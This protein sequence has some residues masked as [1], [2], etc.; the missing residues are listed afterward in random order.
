MACIECSPLIELLSWECDEGGSTFEFTFQVVDTPTV[1]VTINAG[2]VYELYDGIYYGKAPTGVNIIVYLWNHEDC[3]SARLNLREICEEGTGS[4]GGTGGTGGTGECEPTVCEYQG[5]SV[6]AGSV[7]S[8]IATLESQCTL[9]ITLP[10]CSDPDFSTKLT[11][12][13]VDLK[14]AI[15]A[16]YP[17]C[18]WTNFAIQYSHNCPAP[19]LGVEWIY[20]GLI[21]APIIFEYVRIGK[22]IDIPLSHAC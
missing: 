9:N 17:E 21:D 3:I 10:T 16:C 12:A 20:I 8:F 4:T 14:D 6:V 22:S 13:M 7:L 11:Q 2:D 15:E 1:S 5:F 18:D 19:P